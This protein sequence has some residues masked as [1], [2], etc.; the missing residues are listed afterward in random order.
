MVKQALVFAA[1]AGCIDSSS[2]TTQSITPYAADIFLRYGDIKG[3]QQD[4]SSKRTAILSWNF[5][6]DNTGE[7]G[8]I[9]NCV[10]HACQFDVVA[11]TR[12]SDS[13]S[14]TTVW[15]LDSAVPSLSHVVTHGGVADSTFMV[16]LSSGGEEHVAL[17]SLLDCEIPP[18]CGHVQKG[19]ICV[20]I[21][22]LR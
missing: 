2:T 3:E 13:E 12:Q 19:M 7:A 16:N 6:D 20:P 17:V 22:T 14:A 21:C 15:R 9:S 8:V 1:L 10:V 18:D 11:A 5:I 4:P